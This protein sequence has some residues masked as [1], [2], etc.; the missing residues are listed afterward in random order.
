MI[1]SIHVII[2]GENNNNNKKKKEG[3]EGGKEYRGDVERGV[4]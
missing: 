3:R 1:I 2:I 4:L